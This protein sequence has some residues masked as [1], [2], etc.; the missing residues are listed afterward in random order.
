MVVTT[1]E[2]MV[3]SALKVIFCTDAY[4]NALLPMKELCLQTYLVYVVLVEIGH[5]EVEN[6]TWMPSIIWVLGNYP[7]FV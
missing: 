7:I 5:K 1:D 3:I 4:T 6:L 2:G